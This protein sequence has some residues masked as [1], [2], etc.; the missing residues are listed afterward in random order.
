M[1]AQIETAKAAENSSRWQTLL[2]WLAAF[3]QAM[4]YDPE[5]QLYQSHKRLNQQVERLQARVQDL[6]RFDKQET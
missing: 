2:A 3:E 1:T 4:D 5:E 6:E